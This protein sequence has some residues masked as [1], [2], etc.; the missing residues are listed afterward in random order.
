MRFSQDFHIP[1]IKKVSKKLGATITEIC[2]TI[3]G[4]TIK[5]YDRRHGSGDLKE[6]TI[7][8]TFS[9]VPMPKRVDEITYGN[10]FVPLF[11]TL[12]ITDN[13][14]TLL[15]KSKHNIR[16]YIGSNKIKGS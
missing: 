7:I 6:I 5:E 13:F 9:T 16:N 15:N 10:G 1:S 12:P 11:M 14:K 3:V 2:H 8:S 4:L